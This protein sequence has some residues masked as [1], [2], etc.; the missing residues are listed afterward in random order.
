MPLRCVMGTSGGALSGALCSVGYDFIEV[1]E[2]G[3]THAQ[4][5]SKGTGWHLCFHG[6]VPNAIAERHMHTWICTL[7]RST[8]KSAVMTE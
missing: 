5:S 4:T 3:M 2:Q 8:C 6:G 7:G 1:I